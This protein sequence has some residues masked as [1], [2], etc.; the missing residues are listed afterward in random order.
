MSGRQLYGKIKAKD[1]LSAVEIRNMWK[2][3]PL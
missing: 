1:G 3:L 2:H